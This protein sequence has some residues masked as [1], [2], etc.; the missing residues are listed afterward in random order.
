M[1]ASPIRVLLVEDDVQVLHLVEAL[2][3]EHRPQWEVVGRATDAETARASAVECDAIDVA[4]IDHGLPKSAG[5]ELAFDLKFLIPTCTVVVFS[6][7]AREFNLSADYYVVK[8][9]W[10]KL[11]AVLDEIEQVHAHAAGG[12]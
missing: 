7:R 10:P 3:L 8:P 9:N 4:I 2:M 1:G 12:T 5:R 11:E 6:G